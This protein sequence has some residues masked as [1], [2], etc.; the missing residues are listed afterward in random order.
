MSTLGSVLEL[1]LLHHLG[2]VYFVLF[3]RFGLSS[4]SRAA[5][6]SNGIDCSS[7]L[8]RIGRTYYMECPYTCSTFFQ[9]SSHNVISY[10]GTLLIALSFKTYQHYEK[11]DYMT[12]KE[13]L[14][15][16]I[17]ILI[18]TSLT[19]VA[20]NCQPVNSIIRQTLV[21]IGLFLWLFLLHLWP[22]SWVGVSARLGLR[23]DYNAA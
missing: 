23:L 22:W 14:P 2:A 8:T 21:F 18:K 19:Q 15:V 12:T 20:G 10:G 9:S 16:S 7:R 5:V 4:R 1:S 3:I 6:Y 13:E 11:G 17:L